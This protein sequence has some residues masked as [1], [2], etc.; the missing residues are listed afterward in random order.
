MEKMG[1]E[2][3]KLLV[4]IRPTVVEGTVYVH[5]VGCQET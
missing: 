2:R 3:N 4:R 1:Y 5:N